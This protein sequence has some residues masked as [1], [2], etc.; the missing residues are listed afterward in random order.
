MDV[1]N[2]RMTNGRN[3]E[4]PSMSVKMYLAQIHQ[5][6]VEPHPQDTKTEVHKAYQLNVEKGQMQEME[7][8]EEIMEN[9]VAR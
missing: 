8:R 2:F 6:C 3:S 7:K 9:S 4:T 1:M 5:P